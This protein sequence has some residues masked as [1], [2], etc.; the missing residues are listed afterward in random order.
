MD[1]ATKLNYRSTIAHQDGCTGDLG[2]GPQR[3]DVQSCFPCYLRI[4]YARTTAGSALRASLL[5]GSGRTFYER[6]LC[7]DLQVHRGQFSQVVGPRC[8]N[9]LLRFTST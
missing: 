7:A 9:L 8:Y 2:R 5:V 6:I 3:A 1:R 4:V